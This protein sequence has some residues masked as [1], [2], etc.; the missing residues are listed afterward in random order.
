MQLR[1]DFL[2]DAK[3]AYL[4][5]SLLV[6]KSLFD[7]LGLFNPD[8]RYGSDSDF[9]FKAKDAGIEMDVCPEI[10]L[11]RRVH[12]ENLSHAIQA[13]NADLLKL[14]RSSIDRKKQGNALPL[15]S[16]I[17]PVHN[18]EKYL[19]EA[20]DSVLAQSYS[21]IEIIVVDDG[22]TDG[23]ANVARGYGDKVHLHSQSKMGI[24]GGR[25]S[26]IPLAKGGF[27]AFLDSDDL[28]TA[29]KLEKQMALFREDPAVDMVFGNAIQFV[30][31]ELEGKSYSFSAEPM[32]GYV[33]GT[34]LIRREAFSSRRALF[35]GVETGRICRLV[36]KGAGEKIKRGF[37]FRRC[38]KKKDPSSEYGDPGKPVPP[39]LRAD[40]EGLHGQKKSDREPCRQI[41][42]LRSPPGLRGNTTSGFTAGGT[43]L[44]SSAASSLPQEPSFFR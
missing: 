29:D 39:G 10:L 28:W 36:R 4:P 37:I 15:I 32:S 13:S 20:I 3:V 41:L 22:S 26:G 38:V 21:P 2:T 7:T 11:Y 35:D 18:C 24:G 33:A 6:R 43:A 8:F 27:L 12:A 5:G 30:S 9:F 19:K 31:P 40:S 44:S 17:I 42:T 1:S 23:S 14:I 25:N 16:V 34:L